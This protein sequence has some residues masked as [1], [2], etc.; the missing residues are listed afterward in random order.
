MGNFYSEDVEE[1]KG[2]IYSREKREELVEDDKISP[3]ENAF[4]Q[5][6][7]EEEYF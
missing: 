7:E 5:G 6:Y 3:E 4:M 2:T 1:A